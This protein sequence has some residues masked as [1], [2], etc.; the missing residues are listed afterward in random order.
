MYLDDVAL[1]PTVFHLQEK[2]SASR[3]ALRSTTDNQPPPQSS[4]LYS[5]KVSISITVRAARF[6]VTPVLSLGARLS[7][8]SLDIAAI[9]ALSHSK[10]A[11]PSCSAKK[12]KTKKKVFELDLHISQWGYPY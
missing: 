9:R 1:I 3:S 7:I 6:A 8:A 5:E 12:K 2:T 10:S 4:A 11:K